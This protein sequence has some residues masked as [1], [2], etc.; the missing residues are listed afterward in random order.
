MGYDHGGFML[1]DAKGKLELATNQNGEVLNF[2]D[3]YLFYG[4]GTDI[5]T[6]GA[7]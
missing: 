4:G 7:Q 3:P 5:G 1:F 2:A 6:P